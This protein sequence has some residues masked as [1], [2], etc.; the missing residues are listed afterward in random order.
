MR[1]AIKKLK[2][3]FLKDMEEELK[4]LINSGLERK[5]V[6]PNTRL[7][8]KFLRL[9]PRVQSLPLFWYRENWR[10][11]NQAEVIGKIV[12]KKLKLKPTDCLERVK[13]TE[14]QSQLDR[15][16]RLAN[17]TGIFRVKPQRLPRAVLLVDDVWTTG[18]TLSEAAKALKKRGVKQV[19][20]LTL[21]R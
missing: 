10:G 16:K 7:F 17:V 9:K 8:R 5:L 15:E 13:L 19:W 12:A 6:Q 21:A 1:E 11:F 3:R 4:L 2:F 20:G 14:P 18:A